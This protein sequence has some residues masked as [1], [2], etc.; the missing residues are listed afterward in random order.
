MG[1]SSEMMRKK[2]VAVR[3]SRENNHRT[4]GKSFQW[5]VSNITDVK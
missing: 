4:P 3:A 1:E 5:W 2:V